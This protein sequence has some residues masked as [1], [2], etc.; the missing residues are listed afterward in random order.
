[1]FR[2]GPIEAIGPHFRA[3]MFEGNGETASLNYRLAEELLQQDSQIVWVGSTHLPQATNIRVPELP[4]HILPLLEIIPTQVLAYD[5]AIYDGIVPG[6]V[7][8]IQ[9]VITSED[10]IMHPK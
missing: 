6:E 2:Q 4:E 9:R 5:L 7:K 3:M 8:Y 1:M 10:G